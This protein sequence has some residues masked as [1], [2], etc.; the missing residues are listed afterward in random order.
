MHTVVITFKTTNER[1]Y[2][3]KAK[4]SEVVALLE[5]YIAKLN[6]D[7]LEAF[8]SD[9]CYSITTDNGNSL[10]YYEGNAK[11]AREFHDSLDG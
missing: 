9:E 5:T 11:S 10:E 2:Y 4:L 6:S 3:E 7:H 8:F 1:E